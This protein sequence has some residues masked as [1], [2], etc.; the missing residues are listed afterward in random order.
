MQSQLNPISVLQEA[1][2]VIAASEVK[3]TLITLSSSYYINS[4][5]K[6]FDPAVVDN[7]LS[8]ENLKNDVNNL[9]EILSMLL[10]PL[11][12]WRELQRCKELGNQQ[13]PVDR[14]ILNLVG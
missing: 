8:L 4:L 9:R 13:Q 7:D 2:K 12:A 14:D 5:I 11:E 3:D 6:I 10:M 1:R